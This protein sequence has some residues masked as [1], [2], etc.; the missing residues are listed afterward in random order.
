[1]NIVFHLMIHCV[2]LVFVVAR[3]FKK[4]K[5]TLCTICNLDTNKPVFGLVY[6]DS[7]SF[8]N[9]FL[10]YLKKTS[11]FIFLLQNALLLSLCMCSF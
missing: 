2:V 4:T 6:F 7:R 3:F 1:M 5:M 11:Q 9:F 8:S 10:D